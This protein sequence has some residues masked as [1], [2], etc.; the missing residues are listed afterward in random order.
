M[1]KIK[2]GIEISGKALGSVTSAFG[3]TQKTVGALGR[4]IDQAR[5]KQERLGRIMSSAMASASRPLGAMH[6]QYTVLTNV[7][8][9]ATTSQI[10]LNRAMASQ[11][12][13]QDN[14]KALRSQMG[15]TMGHAAVTLGPVAMS[16]KTFMRQEDAATDLKIAMMKASGEIGEFNA[17]LKQ[18]KSLG[19][20]LPGTTEDFINLGRALKEQGVTDQKL[21]GGALRSAANLNVVMGMDQYEGGEFFAKMMEAHGLD[22]K[23]LDRAADITQKAKNAFGL[24]KEDMYGAMRY[25]APQVKAMGLTGDGNYEKMMAIEGTA[26]QSGLEGS[27]FGTNFSGLLN[28][29]SSGPKMIEMASKGMRGVAQDVLK[30]AGVKFEFF[31]AK[32]KFKG[33]DAMVLELEKLKTVREKLG[34]QSA[35]DLATAMF[36]QENSRLALL[37][38][39]GGVA[40]YEK[41]LELMRSQAD[42]S[43]RIAVKTSTLSSALEQMGGVAE[44]TF[45]T[46]GSVFKDDIK[47]FANAAQGFIEDSLEPWLQKNKR[48]VLGTVRVIGSLFAL[49]IGFLAVSYAVSMVVAPFKTLWVVWRRVNAL[50]QIFNV[51]RLTGGLSLLGKS[52]ATTAKKAALFGR[53]L[54]FGNITSSLGAATKAVGVF[55]RALLMTPIGWVAMAIGVVALVIYKYWKPITAFFS[56]VWDGIKE[57]VKPLMPIF[58]KLGEVM[59]AIWDKISPVVTPVIDFFKDLFTVEQVAEGG[60]KSMGEAVGKWIGDRIMGL[61]G[62]VSGVWTEITAAFNGGLLGVGALIL[63]WSPLG[64]FYKAFAGVMSWFGIDLPASFTGFG[65]MI[66]DGLLNGLKAKFESIKTWWSEKASW[67]SGIFTTAN[68]IQ[69][70]SRVFMAHGGHIMDGLAIGLSRGAKRPENELKSLSDRLGLDG[71]TDVS[72]NVAAR[73]GAAGGSGAGGVTFNFSPTIHAPTGSSSEINEG[74]KTAYREFQKMMAQYDRDKNRRSY[75]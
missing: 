3:S 9:K 34:D 15:E 14:R 60:A 33:I 41:N 70:P 44:N 61:V 17:I 43:A 5:Q 46:F 6:R 49:K 38:S 37:I 29:M 4:S 57:G 28:R 42:L 26:A 71:E 25:Y 27:A 12:A 58:D 69:S 24:K 50:M 13:G 75:A 63:N 36:G 1:S 19:R 59:G 11:Q 74:L 30:L 21:V 16:V 55:G 39:E 23:V 54:T 10:K 51:W 35:T 45:G 64:L 67:F 18:A 22:E 48:L 73:N 40:G 52:F 68:K 66:L 2:V 53:S 47:S 32:G 62:I 31:D 20:D 72:L 8:D 7:I 65:S 56:G